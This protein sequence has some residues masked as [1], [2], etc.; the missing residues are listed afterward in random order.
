MKEEQIWKIRSKV[1][2]QLDWT[3]RQEYMNAILQACNL[4]SNYVACDIGTGT[5]VVAYALSKYC[6]DVIGIDISR[7]M[8]NIAKREHDG[9]NIIYK[10]MNAENMKRFTHDTFD[11]V[12]A[13]MVFHHIEHINKAMREVFRILKKGGK[14][15]FSE[16]VPPVGARTFHEEFLTEKED[17]R[18]FTVD[19]IIQLFEINGFRNIDFK[20]HVMKEVS[21]K[22]WLE[23]SGLPK[24]K[25]DFLYRL[26]LDSPKYAQKAENMRIHDGDIL[27]D[28][29]FAIVSG[30]RP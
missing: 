24:A 3:R 28:W 12:T 18:I 1:Y 14:F 30:E 22:N 8:L 19:D 16:G 13:R 25:Q 15:V 26:R 5:G 9:P 21:I 6:K 7:D 4:K 11:V 10:K 23:N 27:T 20:I 29:Y 17:R 2:D